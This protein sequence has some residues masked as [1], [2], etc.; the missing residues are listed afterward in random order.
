MYDT[1]HVQIIHILIVFVPFDM[2]L[3]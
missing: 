3:I 1:V 2:N